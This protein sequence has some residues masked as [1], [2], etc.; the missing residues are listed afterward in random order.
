[1]RTSKSPGLER[2]NIPANIRREVLIE[3]G[4]RCASPRCGNFLAMDIHHIHEVNEGGSN[5][6]SNL[7]AL[8]PMC[9]ALYT[10]G[11]ITKDAI[12]AWKT[13][14]ISLNGAFDRESI[15]NLRFLYK[16]KEEIN[17]NFER[18]LPQTKNWSNSDQNRIQHTNGQQH[19]L[20]Q[21]DGLISELNLILISG[22]GVLKFSHLIASGLVSYH[23]AYVSG[24]DCL[25]TVQLTEKGERIIE[26]WF[27]GDREAVK[28]ALGNLP[29]E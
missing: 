4:Y 12:N 19:K 6:L 18:V 11:I 24:F 14:L 3:A 7:I 5:D 20:A 13:M 10:R 8:C 17:A 1:M 15:S 2:T 21:V 28:E 22:D 16:I 25:Y 29:P 23:L 26:A 9:H 27:S